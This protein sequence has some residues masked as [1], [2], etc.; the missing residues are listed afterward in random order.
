MKIPSHFV[1]EF[2]YYNLLKI[3]DV[4][5]NSIY[6][7]N[8]LIKIYSVNFKK[9]MKYLNSINR[10]FHIL[11]LFGFLQSTISAQTINKY[12]LADDIE[13]L[14]YSNP[15]Q[16]L[17]I[18][19]YLLSKTNTSD[20][21]KSR[22]N[23]LISIAY[24]VKG[25]Y[26][27]ALN[28]LYEEKNYRNYLTEEQKIN[29]DISKI[30]LLRNLTLDKQS[31]KIIEKLENTI[32]VDDKLK[33]YLE[34]SIAI[35]KSKF[36]SN[37][38]KLQEPIDALKK[39]EATVAKIA[40]DFKDIALHYNIALGQLYLRQ[41]NLALAQKQFELALSNLNQQNVEN[42]Y[43]KIDV[44]NGLALVHFLKNEYGEAITLSKE[45]MSYVER[46]GNLFSQIKVNQLQSEIYLAMND[47]ANYKQINSNFFEL[48]SEA[49]G[50]EQ[51]AIN[52]SFNL[53]SDEY[54]DGY[55]DEK[56]KYIKII[57]IVSG[58]FLI[59][60]LI[61]FLFW[62]KI[63]ANK[64]RLVEIINYIEITRSNLMT[65]FSITDK[66]SEPKKNVILKETEEHILN[67]L[68]RF[69]SSKRFINK[70]ISLAV[71]AGQLD[72]NTKYL[73]EIINTHYNVNFNTYIN[74]LRVNYIIEKLKTDPNFINYKIS[75]LAENCG[76][77]SHSSFATV[78]K[79]IT[80]ISPVK[81]I[82][83]LNQEKE[84]NLLE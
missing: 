75:Y 6:L 24:I 44:L 2:C 17:K 23:Y 52:T 49:E 26:S 34:V 28:F 4:A 36:L 64:K 7:L 71:L 19:Q 61:S 69:E 31:K 41:K 78:F 47:V 29:I 45:A 77:S 57:Y 32:V 10:Y 62:Q 40:K 80:G 63:A 25:D 51:E 5:Y 1:K 48:Q 79:T 54:A 21:N 81:F 58:L 74:K 18:A 60:I 73:S 70:D 42:A 43:A 11:L 53:I 35:E 56:S 15:G 33:L 38:S 84:N 72:S 8:L 66:K 55:S 22:I 12:Y 67:K 13:N 30:T 76:F 9:S 27:S 59:V 37:Q 20:S 65:S 46:I 82:E 50:Q 83:L 14:I 68:K 3:I 39:E 16:A